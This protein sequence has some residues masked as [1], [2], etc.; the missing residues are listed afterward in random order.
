MTHFAAGTKP[1]HVL[2][3]CNLKTRETKLDVT[4]FLVSVWVGRLCPRQDKDYRV[5]L[6]KYFS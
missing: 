3:L 2:D 1:R 6:N 5:S 4:H